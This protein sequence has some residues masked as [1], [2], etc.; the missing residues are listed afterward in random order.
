MPEKKRRK[1]FQK[2]RKRKS[3][4]FLPKPFILPCPTRLFISSVNIFIVRQLLFLPTQ[5]LNLIHRDIIVYVF[6]S[7]KYHPWILSISVN[8]WNSN[9]K[10]SL[11]AIFFLK[12]LNSF[13]AKPP[14]GVVEATISS[15]EVKQSEERKLLKVLS[16][17][18]LQ[19]EIE[20]WKRMG[21]LQTLLSLRKGEYA[22]RAGDA[23]D[24]VYHVVSGQVAIGRKIVQ[25]K[26]KFKKGQHCYVEVKRGDESMGYICMDEGKPV[27][28]K[29]LQE[30]R[31]PRPSEEEFIFSSHFTQKQ[32][33]GKTLNLLGLKGCKSGLFL[34]LTGKV[35]EGR[36]YMLDQES[37]HLSESGQWFF[38]GKYIKRLIPITTGGPEM[39]L[40]VADTSG[41]SIQITFHI[42]GVHFKRKKS[43]GLG[44][45]SSGKQEAQMAYFAT[46]LAQLCQRCC[47]ICHLSFLLTAT[48]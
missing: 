33:K 25:Q 32:K 14:K 21:S 36:P 42:H 8:Y 38:Y 31:K 16:N 23:V 4:M 5:L 46:P 34:S 11:F 37:I 6:Y 22:L 24:G 47:K 44:L 15:E 17:V 19:D 43:K 45:F 28:V 30:G 3:Q 40:L 1:K 35:V 20:D 2:G 10:W 29:P 41:T 18:S 39:N 26:T 7:R 48:K 12:T 9:S 13:P 27:Q